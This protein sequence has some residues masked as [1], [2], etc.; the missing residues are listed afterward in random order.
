[1]YYLLLS[2]QEPRHGY[3]VMQYVTDLTG[4]R[5][6]IGAGTLYTLLSR[7]EKEGYVALCEG[8]E[9]NRKLYR[10]TN[11]GEALLWGEFQ[12][13]K[14]LVADGEHLLLP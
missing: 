7:F 1:M 9:G 14:L 5:V 10:L 11:S 8:G 4:G 6:Q 2:L 12:R 13:L 3:A